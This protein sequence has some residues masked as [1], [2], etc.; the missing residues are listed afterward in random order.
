MKTPKYVLSVLLVLW[1][2]LIAFSSMFFDGI[3]F[4][5]LTLTT[6]ISIFMGAG[7][8]KR[9]ELVFFI[10]A[11]LWMIFSAETIGFNMFYQ[12]NNYAGL[13]FGMIPFILSAIMMFSIKYVSRFINSSSKKLLVIPLCLL[14]GIGSH[15]YKPTTVEIN[16]WYYFDHDKTYTAMFAIAP[17]QTFQVELNSDELKKEVMAEALQYEGRNGYYC[18]ETKVRVVTSFGKIISVRILSFR[19]SVTDKKINFSDRVKIPLKNVNG[20]LE[21]LK[22]WKVSVWY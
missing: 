7:K 22:P 13:I 9:A 15:I 17:E 18:P 2:I 10:S 4:P 6:I 1:G 21:I 11:C 8:H 14:I 19:N 16:C 12:K 5:F 20:K 3:Q